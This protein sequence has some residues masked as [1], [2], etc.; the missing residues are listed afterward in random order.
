M[1]DSACSHAAG[2]T[3]SLTCSGKEKSISQKRDRSS[4]SAMPPNTNFTVLWSI[5]STSESDALKPAFTR[6]RA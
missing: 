3:D 1:S 2:V 5:S 6:Q 4:E